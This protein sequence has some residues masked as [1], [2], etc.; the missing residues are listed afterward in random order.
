[1]SQAIKL[2]LGCGPN[3][4]DG[5]VNVDRN[6]PNP[7]LLNNTKG[8]LYSLLYRIEKWIEIQKTPEEKRIKICDLSKAFPFEDNSVDAIF[9]SHVVEHFSFSGEYNSDRDSM[10]H[11]FLR[12]CHRVLKPGGIMRCSTPDFDLLQT[13]LQNKNETYFFE[14]ILEDGLSKM[15]TIEESFLRILYERS[16]HGY[17]F[18]YHILEKLLKFCG[19]SK[20]EKV[21]FRQ[22]SSELIDAQLM[23]NRV[24]ESMFLE[25]FK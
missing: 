1:M 23:D 14:D 4:Y 16:T 19:F 25:A 8:K 11:H 9:H 10:V 3:I 15:E 22:S 5:W 21:D 17:C 6:V 7:K 13:H 24:T 12:E 18:N 2:H 20:V